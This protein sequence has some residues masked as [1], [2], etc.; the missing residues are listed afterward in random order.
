MKFGSFVSDDGY[1]DHVFT[2]VPQLF[3][4]LGKT[5]TRIEGLPF[6]EMDL[7]TISAVVSYFGKVEDLKISGNDL[8]RKMKQLKIVWSSVKR[9]TIFCG[10]KFK[11]NTGNFAEFPNV[12]E[13][14]LKFD[15]YYEDLNHIFRNP[16]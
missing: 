13:I 9:L 16:S 11:K 8:I 2:H 3:E 6:H 1:A 7:K 10:S 12:E 14:I 15:E 5:V 4:K